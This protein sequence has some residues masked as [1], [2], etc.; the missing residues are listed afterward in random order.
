MPP[1]G[2]AGCRQAGYCGG[3]VYCSLSADGRLQ[4]AAKLGLNAPV[5][6]LAKTRIACGVICCLAL[7]LLIALGRTSPPGGPGAQA[8]QEASTGEGARPSISDCRKCHA[9]VWQEWN[10][11]YH[12]KAFSDDQVQ[13]AF[14]HFGFDRKCQSCHAPQGGLSTP[15]MVLEVRQTDQASGVTC[16]NC[17]GLPDG[18]I[19]GRRTIAEAPCRPQQSALLLSSEACGACHEAIYKDWHAS[20]YRTEGKSCQSCHMPALANRAGGR[21]HLCTGSHDEA[22]VRSGVTLECRQE[23]DELIVSA[24]NH[25]TGH[26]FPGER[27]NRVLYLQVLE[28]APDG[29]ITLARQALIKG[30]TPFRGESSREQ[31]R[32]DQTFEA[33]FPVVDPPVRAEVRLLY[34][35]FPWYSDDE[36]L[37]VHRKEVELTAPL[38][39]L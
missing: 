25:A 3:S 1:V 22:L 36:A 26:N 5:D 15:G 4:L 28:R 16:L 32:V 37:T 14:E 10:D 18:S 7:A 9:D 34:K 29:Q 27:H 17:H 38:G 8:R 2:S 31:I 20:R 35:P 23:G 13:A 39:K 33:R 21:S 12:A 11:S 24:T 30:I 19:A 6:M